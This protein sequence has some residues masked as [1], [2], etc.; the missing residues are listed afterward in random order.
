[1]RIRIQEL[2]LGACG[3]ALVMPVAAA[4]D[5]GLTIPIEA[6]R[7]DPGAAVEIPVADIAG[8]YSDTGDFLRRLPGIS[9]IR[10]GGLGIEPVIRGQ[11]GNRINV[12]LDGAY[13]YGGCPNRMDPP[14]SYAPLDSYERVTVFKGNQTVRYGGGGSGGTVILER[15]TPR[16]G[17]GEAP[18]LDVGVD[19]ASNG[20]ARHGLADAA[21]GGPQGFARAIV[22]YKQAGNY[23]D[24]DGREVRSAYREG[25]GNLILGYT[26]DAGSR[27]ELGLESARTEDT[28]Y[29]GTM[30][31]PE[32]RSDTVRLKYADTDLAGPFDAVHA[33]LYSASVH[34]VMDNYSFRTPAMAVRVP[35]DSDTRGGRLTTE[36]HRTLNHWTLGLDYQGNRRE[37]VRSIEMMST[38]QS[39]SLLWP[40]ADIT[41]AGVF[42]EVK[43]PLDA[44]SRIGA[45]LRHD[46]VDAAA[47]RAGEAPDAA[48]RL[49]PDALYQLY[50]GTAAEAA[51]ED[52]VGGFLRY[53]QDL[54]RR[55]LSWFAAVSRGV[56]TADATE[57]YIAANAMMM[58][59]STRWVGDP[60]LDPEVHR[61]VEIGL[62]AGG[63]RWR[64]AGS[65]FYDDVR[66]YILRDR[67]AGQ[68]G[69]LLSDGASVYRNVSAELYGAEAEVSW[70]WRSAWVAR[71]SL[72]YVHATN[73]SDDRPVAK[74]PPLE[75]SLGLDYDRG[76]WRWGGTLRWAD[77]QTR[78]DVASGQDLGPT[79]GWGVLDLSGRYRW[80]E[81]GELA[82][83]VDNVFDRTYA[84]HLT[85]ETAFDPSVYR[86]N[87]PGRNLWV[88]ASLS[89]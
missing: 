43:R 59:P 57:R 70:G 15:E 50:Y 85:R 47:H 30:D 79:P 78:A 64:L 39:E 26:P 12:L 24:G 63:G 22:G 76:A 65:V 14:T 45:G 86:V 31:S 75:G 11:A 38:W 51:S 2:L 37:A 81:R 16:F 48:G 46:R 82:L 42:A 8:Q 25:N 40:D 56:R 18:R 7:P 84:E 13:V 66:D 41:Q 35:S 20:E 80:G 88:N 83:G 54:A 21:A 77:D 6:R 67:A 23:R 49:S 53:E 10:F 71:I 5:T 60:G 28:L 36:I 87:E 33:E 68:E 58:D 55:D 69:V 32:S 74:T 19:Y 3:A 4:E 1:M 72:S 73:T 27:Y 89:F 44:W 17:A 29:I 61:Q 52:N 34:H 9:G 62:S